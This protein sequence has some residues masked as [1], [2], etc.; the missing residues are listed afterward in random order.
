MKF[1]PIPIYL[2]SF[3]VSATA[4]AQQAPTAFPARPP[5]GW[6]SWP[7]YGISVTEAEVKAHADYMEKHLRKFGWEYIVVDMAWYSDL[8]TTQEALGTDLSFKK[9]KP[10]QYIDRY[11]RVIPS[12]QKFPSSAGGRGFRGLADYI[13][14]KGLK[15][16]V[17]IMRGIPWQA[18]ARNTP[19]EGTKYTARDIVSY[20]NAC[21]WYSGMYSLNWASPGA[22]AYYNSLYR[23]LASW[24]VDFVKVDDM[25]FPYAAADV[26]GVRSAIDASGKPIVLS[27]SPGSTPFSERF[28]V[29]Q[30]A[31]MFRISRDFWDSWKQLKEQFGLC[32]QWIYFQKAGHWADADMLILGRVNERSE[33]GAPRM[34]NFTRDEQITLMTLWSIFRSPLMTGSDFTKM[35]DWTL[36]L[37]T[38]EELLDVNQR[39]RNTRVLYQPMPARF[40]VSESE[41]SGET[42]I[43]TSDSEDGKFH[44]LAFFNLSDTPQRVSVELKRVGLTGKAI[45]RDIWAK[46]DL[47]SFEILL[48]REI[49]PHGAGLYK[50]WQ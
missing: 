14:S 34:T 29:Q 32:N 42:Q 47:G 41:L 22:Q 13:H 37:Y 19:V 4:F 49:K 20:E 21:P 33:M 18:V 7:N 12:E 28:H 10:E 1:S 27:L 35:D 6:N 9:P 17:H 16:G 45:V 40:D 25:S 31:A 23:M 48:Q 46:E 8:L 39:S 43:W 44:Y 5:M 2:L 30:H 38:N 36:S 50:V 24:G 26:Q 3:I 11:G 15:F